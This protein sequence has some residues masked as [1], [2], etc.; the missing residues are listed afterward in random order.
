MTTDPNTPTTAWIRDNGTIVGVTTDVLVDELGNFFVDESSNNLLDS[1]SSDGNQAPAS[2]NG[3]EDDATLWANSFEARIEEAFRTT[4]SGDTRVTA[5][6]DT[7]IS[8]YSDRNQQPDTAWSSEEE[9]AVAWSNSFG[10]PSFVSSTRTTAQGDTRVTVSGD[11]RIAT[12]SGYVS[13]RPTAWVG[14]YS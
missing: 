14:E 10:T 5:S 11:T 8:S 3:E 6:G 9:T 12:E 7:R 2:W 1:V 4:V 13:K